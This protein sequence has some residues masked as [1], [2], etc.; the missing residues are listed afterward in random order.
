VTQQEVS[1]KV[2]AKLFTSALEP[3]DFARALILHR[4]YGP[5]LSWDVTNVLLHAVDR[6]AV[7]RV[8]EELEQHW[9]RHLQFQHP[10]IRGRVCA[11]DTGNATENMFLCVC[12][13]VLDL[14]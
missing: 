11:A 7:Q 6:G 1:E 2:F 5:A 4:N 14:G 12:T 10:E 3:E 8:L 13:D 9:E